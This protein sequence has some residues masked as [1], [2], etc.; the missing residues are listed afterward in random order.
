M[1]WLLVDECACGAVPRRLGDVRVISVLT[2]G[3]S[4]IS[5]SFVSLLFN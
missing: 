2:L 5:I 4:L 1:W 3:R